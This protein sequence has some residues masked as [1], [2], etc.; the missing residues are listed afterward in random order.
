MS[1]RDTQHSE[2]DSEFSSTKIDTGPFE[3]QQFSSNFNSAKKDSSTYQTYTV[4]P[5][6]LIEFANSQQRIADKPNTFSSLYDDLMWVYPDSPF[7]KQTTPKV[8]HSDIPQT[9]ITQNSDSNP[10]PLSEQIVSEKPAV[11]PKPLVELINDM[12][13]IVSKQQDEKIKPLTDLSDSSKQIFSKPF[14]STKIPDIEV[15]NSSQ[16]ID[17]ENTA[18]KTKP[19]SEFLSTSQ[20]K[21]IQPVILANRFTQTSN[22]QQP[23]D[24]ELPVVNSK[25]LSEI[26]SNQQPSFS[27]PIDLSD[28][29]VVELDN[30]PQLKDT[31]N[32]IVKKLQPTKPDKFAQEPVNVP[33]TIIDKPITAQETPINQFLQSSFPQGLTYA[34]EPLRGLLDDLNS[35]GLLEKPITSIEFDEPLLLSSPSSWPSGINAVVQHAQNQVRILNFLA[36]D[37]KPSKFRTMEEF[38]LIYMKPS[39]MFK[40]FVVCKFERKLTH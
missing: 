13:S 32:T 23:I 19:L 9:S 36:I 12:Q 14:G 6:P 3:Y 10:K 22:T 40:P 29:R 20:P 16:A 38:S 33:Q 28:N 8:Q 17:S 11:K 24:K 37:G 35:L 5:K 7:I 21:A 30:T 34:A 2:Q 39:F 15:Q 27:N 4:K 26:F 1:D 25:P 31:V 18:S